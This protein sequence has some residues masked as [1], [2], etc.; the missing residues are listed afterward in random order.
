[1]DTEITVALI[2]A[3]GV[4][5]TIAGA[6]V[7]ARIQANGGLAQAQAARD[8]ADTVAQSARRQALHDLRW[9]TMTALLRA[10]GECVEASGRLY[11]AAPE[12]SGEQAEAEQVLH[13]FRLAFAEAELAAPPGVEEELAAV[14]RAV[15]TAHH[16]ART[17]APGEQAWRE[18]DRLSRQGDAAAARAKGALAR[19]RAEGAPVWNPRHGDGDPPPEY[20][21]A[22]AALNAVP[23]LERGQVRL[24]LVTAVEP[25]EY[26][27]GHEPTQAGLRLNARREW[28][29]RNYRYQEARQELIEA[30]RQVLGTDGP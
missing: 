22:I 10:A 9:R 18:L 26:E 1:M 2:G 21:A 8:A 16:W 7:G 6:I 14:G 23:Q 25:L 15:R 13:A 28:A 17:R 12:A 29:Q 5:G 24:L 20:E 19:L 3:A 27:R 11:L 30:A 4:C